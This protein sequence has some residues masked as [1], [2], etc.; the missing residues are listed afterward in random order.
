[1]VLI[2]EIAFWLAAAVVAY[3]YLGYPTI[4]TF[5]AR[6]F[7]RPHTTAPITPTVTIIIPA[8]NEAGVIAQK[9]DNTL[10][11]NYPADRRQV[12]VVTDGSTD[13]TERIAAAYADRG[14]QV[15]HQPQR[16]GKP[17]A[18]NRG[19]ATATGEVLVFT[20]ANTLL[21]QDSLHHLVSHFAD[22]AVAAVS[23]EKQVL[24][25]TGSTERLGESFVSLSRTTRRTELAEVG[26]LAAQ[27]EGLY[28]RYESYLKRCDSALSSVMGAAGEL[29]AVR[30][31]RFQPP[32]ADTLLD[33][34]YL[35]LSL[36][37]DGWR[38]VYEPQAIAREAGSPDLRSEWVRRRRNA[39][40]GFQA[41][42]RLLPL[43]DPRRGRIA[44]Q[45]LSHRVLRWAVAP[46]L[47]LLLLPLNL[48]LLPTGR[49]LYWIFASG[50]IFFYLAALAGLSRRSSHRLLRV[51]AY[52]LLTNLAALAGLLRF[53]TGRQSVLWE[54]A[55]R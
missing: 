13:G 12:I 48:S 1:M 36:V 26:S 25:Q 53:L 30:R 9:L 3:T 31:S 15:L 8:Y 54:K 46:G 44:F 45:Y 14:V 19:A 22:P 38:V 23:G 42:S 6:R 33:D 34:F 28:W 11:L 5:L 7:A 2:L 40:G 4:V 32:P 43:L 41:M 16:Q 29:F 51:P 17:A 50:Q 52:F 21:T 37:R 55:Q 47:L 18:M 39:A 20:D 24:P 10:A 49:L 35:S 27:G